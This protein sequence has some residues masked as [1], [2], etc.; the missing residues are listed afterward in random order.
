MDYF[1][2][3]YIS[4]IPVIVYL[5]SV[6]NFHRSFKGRETEAFFHI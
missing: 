6:L 1:E 5:F 3:I 2:E 4:Y